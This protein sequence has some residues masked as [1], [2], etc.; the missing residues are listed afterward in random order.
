MRL[1][2]LAE[3][4]QKRGGDCPCITACEAI[5]EC[6]REMMKAVTDKQA[7][8]NRI[9]HLERVHQRLTSPTATLREGFTFREGLDPVIVFDG[10][11]ATFGYEDANGDWVESNEWPFN[12]SYV[13]SDDCERHGIRV[14]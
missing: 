6:D 2:Q 12:E 14:E 9:R 13:F 10:E 5:K 8:E 7:A 4:C 1:E 11:E 3:K